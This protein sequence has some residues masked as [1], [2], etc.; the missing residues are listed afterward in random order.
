[1]QPFKVE[2][3]HEVFHFGDDIQYAAHSHNY[4][5]MVWLT[6]G[7]GT[8]HIDLNKCQIGTNVVFCIQPDQV[9]RF[10]PGPDV[11][12]YVFSFTHGF[13]NYAEQEF[14]CSNQIELY[15]ILSQ[16]LPIRI[17]GDAESVLKEI[18]KLMIREYEGQFELRMELLRRYFRIFMIYLSR[19]LKTGSPAALQGQ[20]SNLVRAFLEMLDHNFK[21]KKMVAEYAEKLYITPNYLNRVIKKNTG[22]S[23]RHHIKQRVLLEAKRLGRYSDVGMKQIA[24]SLGFADSS[25]FSKFF[26]SGSGTNFSEFKNLKPVANMQ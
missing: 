14:D 3:I 2:T 21:E 16:S 20:E 26:K 1:M 10:E 5:E 7:S 18:I 13:F 22:L 17:P 11:E 6:K 25:H 8:L 15:Q 24:Y 4:Y 23:A 19:L 12:G 9:H